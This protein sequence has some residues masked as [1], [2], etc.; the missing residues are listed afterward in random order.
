MPHIDRRGLL[1][2]GSAMLLAGGR[3]AQAQTA[4][5]AA[6]PRR[7]GVLRWSMANNPGSLD[8]MTGRTAAEF[9]FLYALYDALLDID[10]HTLE[11]KPG[12]ARAWRFTDPRTLVLDLVENAV[13]HDGTPFNA[14]AVRINLERSR[15]DKRSNVRADIAT[16]ASVEATGPYQVALHLSR[17]NAALP[18]ILT[19]RVG[20]MVSPKAISEQGNLD[21]HPVG[22]GPWKLVSWNDNERAVM[23]RN[24][25]YWRPGLPYLDGLNIAIITEPTTGLR[26]VIAGENDLAINLGP[27]QKIIAERAKLQVELS[28]TVGMA[29]VYLNIGRPPFDDIRIRQALNYAVDRE[30]LNKVV[31]LGLNEPGCAILP[32]ESWACDP[33]TFDY[34]KH[35]PGRARQLLADAGHADGIDIPMLGWS[36]QL[37]MQRQE[38]IISQLA[39]AGIRIRL[40]PMSAAE[41]SALFFGPEKRGAGRMALIAGRPDPSQEY[42]NLFSGTAYFNAGGVEL[43]GFRDL[44]DATM[45]TT[46]RDE[47]RAAFA[48]LQRFTVEIALGLPLMFTTAVSAYTSHVKNFT[49]GAMDKPKVTEVWLDA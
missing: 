45:N 8:P 17:P 15:T 43:P 34:Y 7:G 22:T 18:A 4:P 10:P 41:S 46:D 27:Q 44:L 49:F 24:D 36:D 31:A 33:A 13:F 38:V 40:T 9:C 29:G 3:A 47:R 21:R 16:V 25:A 20:L 23:T 37:S 26:S 32:R 6:T 5:A 48:R 2:A 14:E 28:R 11:P 39:Q 1:A 35:D 19:D 12:L 42:D 30:E